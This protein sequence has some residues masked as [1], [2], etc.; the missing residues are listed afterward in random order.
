M[1]A[2]DPGTFYGGDEDGYT[3]YPFLKST[4]TESI[5]STLVALNRLLA[6]RVV[7]PET[8][9]VLNNTGLGQKYLKLAEWG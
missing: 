3:D 1:N 7:G 4:G 9:I 5:I 2:A 8:T 6:D